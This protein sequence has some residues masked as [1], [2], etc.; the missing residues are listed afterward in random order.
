[1][2]GIRSEAQL[3]EI[4]AGRG[5]AVQGLLPVKAVSLPDLDRMLREIDRAV[6][7]GD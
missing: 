4:R 3:E 5:L 6:S 1:V 2:D 7:P